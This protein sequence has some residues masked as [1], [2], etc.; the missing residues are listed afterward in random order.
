MKKN[1]ERVLIFVLGCTISWAYFAMRNSS[2]VSPPIASL[3]EPTERRETTRE[4]ETRKIAPKKNTAPS[5]FEV[6]KK[7]LLDGK[8]TE[9]IQLYAHARSVADVSVSARYR[10]LILRQIT[11]LSSQNQIVEAYEL[12]RSFLDLEYDD[13]DALMLLARLHQAQKNYLAAI[14]TMYSAKSYAH[15][16]DKINQLSNTI[17][18]LVAEYKEKLNKQSNDLA[19][20]ELYG[21]LTVLEPDYALNYIGLAQA[22]IALGNNEDARRAL[23]LASLDPAVSYKANELLNIINQKPPVEIDHTSAVSLKRSGDQFAVEASLNNSVQVTLLLDTGASLSII[24]FDTLAR[25]G[26]SPDHAIKTGWFTTANGV[27]QAPIISLAGFTVGGHIVENIEVGVMD[28]SHSG[29][30]D[31]LLGM[32]FLKH[33]KFYIDQSD[34]KMHLQLR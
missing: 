15:N 19:L 34:N 26:M 1:I 31:G 28:I 11:T 17:R 33:F 8:Y 5:E 18:S 4:Q 6:A 27:V 2:V 14:D 3:D 7:L 32:N 29:T 13:V 12:V 22:H 20:L 21:R 23:S 16:I 24:S 30:I 10:H 9:F 25:L